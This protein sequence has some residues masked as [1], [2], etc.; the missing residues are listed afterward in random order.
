MSHRVNREMCFLPLWVGRPQLHSFLY[1]VKVLL[2]WGNEVPA[3][4]GCLQKKYLL[5]LDASRRIRDDN[6]SASEMSSLRVCVHRKKG[7][8][9]VQLTEMVSLNIYIL[10]IQYIWSFYYQTVAKRTM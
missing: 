5:Q 10:Y 2:S 9:M 6:S 4:R 7:I 1:C 8:N 3:D